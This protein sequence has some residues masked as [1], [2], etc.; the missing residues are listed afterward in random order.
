M[1]TITLNIQ[2]LKTGLPKDELYKLKKLAKQKLPVIL[3]YLQHQENSWF[4]QYP[5]TL[6]E[7]ELILVNSEKMQKLNYLYRQKDTSTNVLSLQNYSKQELKQGLKLPKI[8]IGSIIICINVAKEEAEQSNIPFYEYFLKLLIHGFLHVIGYDHEVEA[9]AKEMH[10]LENYLLKK[11]NL[12]TYGII[13]N[14][15]K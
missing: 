7:V 10:A 2:G 13:A 3:D 15:W 8:L 4:L 14:Y 9:E 1:A 6:L 11:L 12:N 5:N